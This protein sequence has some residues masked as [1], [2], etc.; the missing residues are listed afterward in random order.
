M[1]SLTKA[2]TVALLI[3][4]TVTLVICTMELADEIKFIELIA[5]GFASTIS[6]I[7]CI[8]AT[9]GISLIDTES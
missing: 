6:V 2:F 8:A 9:V 1:T 5:L 7:G 4:L 3:M